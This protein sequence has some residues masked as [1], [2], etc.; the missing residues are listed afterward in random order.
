MYFYCYVYV[1]LLLCMF[2]ILFHCVVLCIF[3]YKCVLYYCHRVSTQVQ[4]TNTSH[5]NIIPNSFF[6]NFTFE[7]MSSRNKGIS[8][9]NLNIYESANAYASSQA[10]EAVQSNSSSSETSPSVT[11]YLL[12][13]VQLD[14]EMKG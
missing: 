8:L 7:G 4:L 6:R 2:C 10:F 5:H 12:P 3:L 11:G 14:N 9:R 13:N 1:F